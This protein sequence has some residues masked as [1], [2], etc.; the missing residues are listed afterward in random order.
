[1]K[2]SSM[3]AA[4]EA[5]KAGPSLESIGS[6]NPAMIESTESAGMHT[7]RDTRAVE[8]TRTPASKT[9]ASAKIAATAE[10]PT[11]RTK[12]IAVDDTR[13][14]RDKRVVVVDDSPAATPIE[15]PTVPSPAEAGKQ[16]D[17][18]AQSKSDSRPI[19]EE[20]RIRIPGGKDS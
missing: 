13:A 3:E 11:I 8:P 9:A 18:E 12:A 2:S 6:G 17:P 1:M 4:S 15:S 7:P 16:T 5:A 14:T 19:Q 10:A 20:P